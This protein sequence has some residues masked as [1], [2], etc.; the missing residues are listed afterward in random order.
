MAYDFETAS[1]TQEIANRAQEVANR[2]RNEAWYECLSTKLC[3]TQ[4]THALAHIEQLELA[5]RALKKIMDAS[6]RNHLEVSL[7]RQVRKLIVGVR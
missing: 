6:D 1:R 2:I 7:E 5:L 3:S 4:L